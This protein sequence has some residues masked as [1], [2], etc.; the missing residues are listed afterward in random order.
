MEFE[1]SDIKSRRLLIMKSSIRWRIIGIVVLIVIV[2]IGSLASI[3]SMMIKDKTV[4]AVVGQSESLVKQV[5]QTM[6]SFLQGYEQSLQSMALSDDVKAFAQAD[7]TYN[8]ADD[9]VYRKQLANFIASYPDASS[10]Y[11][12]DASSVTIEPHFDGVKEVDATTRAWYINSMNKPGSV[13]WTSPYIDQSTGNSTITG[14]ITVQDGN[15]IIGVLG[16][17]ILL[18]NLTA[19]VSAIELGY[20]GIPVIIDNEGVAIVH[21][22]YAGE[23]ISEQDAVAKILQA[24]NESGF[25]KSNID[26]QQHIVVYNKIPEI[27]WNIGAVYNEQKL[28]EIAKSIEKVIFM[29]T[30]VIIVIMFAVLFIVI[31]R[32]VRPLQTLGKLMGRVANGD[33]TA[34]IDL[35]SKDEIGQLAKNFNSMVGEMKDIVHVVQQSSIQVEQRSQHLSAMAEETNASSMLVSEAV[36][37]IAASTNEASEHNE[38]VTIQTNDLGEHINS[39]EKHTNALHAVT[40]EASR[41]NVYGQQNMHELLI[42]FEQS[43]ASFKSMTNVVNSLEHKISTITEVIDTINAISNQTNL[44][45]LNASIEAARAGEHGKG[46]AVVADEVRK[47]AEQTAIATEQVQTTITTLQQES[48]SIVLQMQDMEKSVLTQGS[49]V[50]NTKQTF[51]DI[52][53]S[54]ES[55]EQT[56]EVLA[57]ALSTMMQSKEDVIA[58]IE[59]LAQNSQAIAATCEEVSASSDEQLSAIQNVTEECEQLNSLSNDLAIAVKKF[60]L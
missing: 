35:H 54:M 41:L 12:A 4:S 60:T 28:N 55:V 15:K 11:F 51:T 34:K 14:S 56:F 29:I 18:D 46:F 47:L 5:S 25:V 27:G 43:Q 8:S 24:E 26:Q 3:S 2:G 39:L 48:H 58:T 32:I 38:E 9:K 19:M 53:T 52:S 10:I 44:L 7:R 40:N 13:H 33:L 37:E 36:A 22:T 42:S 16:V 17:D 20:D 21:P 59:E 50:T 23:N 31:S 1:F 6:D 57:R 45:A 30:V 49:V